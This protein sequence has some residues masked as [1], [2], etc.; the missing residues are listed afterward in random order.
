MNEK[1]L[2]ANYVADKTV[3]KVV[4]LMKKIIK[5]KS[6]A[7]RW[8]EKS[9]SFSLGEKVQVK[10]EH[11]AQNSKARLEKKTDKWLKESV[12]AITIIPESSNTPKMCSKR[13]VA[14]A[15]EEQNIEVK[16]K[17]RRRAGGT[18]S[19][20]ENEDRKNK[21]QKTEKKGESNAPELAFDFEEVSRPS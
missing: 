12:H 13:D 1:L 2:P 19:S 11:V 6:A 21:R 15:T 4:L 14:A 16:K 17:L 5:S 8:R 9:H 20:C 18:T 3:H 7:C 10:K